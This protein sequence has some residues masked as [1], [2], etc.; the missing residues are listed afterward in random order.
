MKKL[1][2]KEI[3][4]FLLDFLI[5]FLAAFWTFMLIGQILFSY[6]KPTPFL[7]GAL[8]LSVI[9]AGGYAWWI[10]HYN[11]ERELETSVPGKKITRQQIVFLIILILICPLL[12]L[13]YLLIFRKAKIPIRISI[14][15]LGLPLIMMIFWISSVM[16]QNGRPAIGK[17]VTAEECRDIVFV[18][19]GATDISYFRSYSATEFECLCTEEAFRKWARPEIETINKPE[20]FYFWKIRNPGESFEIR[21]GLRSSHHRSNG[22]GYN[23]V[24]DLDTGRLYLQASPR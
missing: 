8:I 9:L 2:W 4:L 15:C 17:H 18:P 21:W 6:R 10:M 5:G 24:Y 7:L 3:L 1:C 16:L 19:D 14:G 12:G 22:G 11:R 13:F 20:R 23:A